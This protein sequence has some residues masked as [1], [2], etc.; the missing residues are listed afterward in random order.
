VIPSAILGRYSQSL[1]EVASEEK[2]EQAVSEDLKTFSE[3]FR[4]VPDL[5]GVF[6]A[7]G[8]P[9]EAKE[10]L[11]AELMAKYPV[12]LITSN[13]LR[14]LLQHH[15]ILYFQLIAEGYSRSVNERKGIVSARVTAAAPVSPE[16]LR[17]LEAKLAEVT[18]KLVQIEA[19]TDAGLLGGVVVQ[20]GSTI[21]DGSIRT[22]L[23]EMRRRLTES[24]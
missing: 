20:I 21:F 4:A 24:Y 2:L 3:I 18:G 11:L 1:A 16:N 15:R 6:H 22:Q 10:K 19:R 9:R 7:P 13:F 8:I 14:I 12:S 23:A 5:L 17:A